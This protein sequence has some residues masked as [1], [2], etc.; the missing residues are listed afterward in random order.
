MDEITWDWRCIG[1]RGAR[2]VGKTTLLLQRL[3][4]L[5]PQIKSVYLTLDDIHFGTF[6]LKDTLETFRLHGYTY[7]FLDEVHK[8]PDWSKE[9]KNIYDLYPEIYVIFTGS[10]IIELHLQAVDLSRRAVMYDL[11]GL[12]FREYLLLNKIAEIPA[13]KLDDLLK[14]HREIALPI[15][16]KIRP[17]QHLQEYWKDGYFPFFLENRPLAVV[18]IKQIIQ[19]VLQM[20]ISGANSQSQKLAR[21]LQFIA[22]SSPFKPNI[23]NISRTLSLDRDTVMRYLEQLNMAQ[24][25]I[26]LYGETETL[27][28]LQRPEKIYLQNNNFS[29]ALA[30]VTP[31]LGNLRETF[32]LNQVMVKN[33]IKY[34]SQADFMVNDQFLF[35]IG[36]L[37]KNSKQIAGLPNAYLALDEIETG[38]E[39]RIPLWMFGLLY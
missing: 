29:F 1:I 14:N 21:L 26:A 23:S 22:T 24:L 39:N 10:N 18:R 6:T 4:T 25:I 35:E 19:L 16:S 37:G 2:G 17:I 38:L 7:F 30:A 33:D 27:S 3:K 15:I 5:D 28:A 36:G 12:S 13:V 8:Y 20:D 31:E 9:I 34:P 32:F 11:P